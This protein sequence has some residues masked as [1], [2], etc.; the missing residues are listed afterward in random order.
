MQNILSV[1]RYTLKQL[2]R[3]KIYLVVVLF[4]LIMMVA[5]VVFSSL[6]VEQRNRMLMDLGLAS[7][8]L[9][10]ILMAIFTS[11]T[12]ILEELEARTLYL[13]L[14]RPIR[15][16]EYILGR[17]FGMLLSV[18]L[19]IL[20]MAVLHV[21]FLLL[22][23]TAIR[24]LYPFAIFGSLGKVFLISALAIFI[25]LFSSSSVVA[26][27]FTVFF[28]LL[29]HYSS[30]LRFIAQKAANP[31]I[32]AIVWVFTYVTPDLSYFNYKDFWYSPQLPGIAWFS[33][34]LLYCLTYTVICL[35]LANML[36]V[37]KE[38]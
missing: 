32:K 21:G 35:L 5:S 17:Y 1:C 23:G 10:A 19:G 25:S 13:I 31:L 7:I 15:R 26:M 24:L 38:L 4:G 29:G 16:W 3:N 6:A 12:L 11:V 20:I 36:L 37:R 22:D 18:I 27:I 33:W 28:W 9:V 2:L 14:T 30:E 34:G 8:E